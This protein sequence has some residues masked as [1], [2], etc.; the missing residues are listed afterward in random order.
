[1]LLKKITD[2][3]ITLR[4]QYSNVHQQLT[5]DFIPLHFIAALSISLKN[6]YI[7]YMKHIYWL[8]IAVCVCVCVVGMLRKRKAMKSFCYV[9]KK[10]GTFDVL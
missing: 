9:Y 3:G 1:M 10:G 5:T 7:I 4:L 2:C 6:M 8:L